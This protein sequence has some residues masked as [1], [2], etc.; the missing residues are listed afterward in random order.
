MNT[1][2]ADAKVPPYAQGATSFGIDWQNADL[3]SMFRTP[4]VAAIP[5]VSQ[6]SSEIIKLEFGVAAN[7]LFAW[8]RV[9]KEMASPEV[10]LAHFVDFGCGTGGFIEHCMSQFP[11]LQDAQGIDISQKMITLAQERNLTGA[12]FTCGDLEAL[13]QHKQV[14]LITMNLVSN[15]L[16][17]AQIGE[18]AKVASSV[19]AQDGKLIVVDLHPDYI[20]ACLQRGIIYK[21]FDS[22]EYPLRGELEFSP[23]NIAHVFVHHDYLELMAGSPSLRL[24][25]T[26]SLSLTADFF[27][28]FAGKMPNAYPTHVP[29]YRFFV[30]T[31]HEE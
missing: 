11:G 23:G 20:R 19:L 24:T 13:A 6:V 29:R 4:S 10:S 15:Y 7:I 12:H 5:Q 22:L 31:K 25:T 30:F 16:S 14:S 9:L 26:E 3:A 2:T 17:P 8:S 28:A 18:L 21:N 1:H 27:E